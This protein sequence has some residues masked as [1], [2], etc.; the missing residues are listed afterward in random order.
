MP[1]VSFDRIWSQYDEDTNEKILN[2]IKSTA[3]HPL[4]SELEKDL[5]RGPREIDLVRSALED[6]MSRAYTNIRKMKHTHQMPDL[7]SASFAYAIERL[8]TSYG[9]H[10]IFP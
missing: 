9:A 4:D 1:H 10:G 8:A 2:L 3:A 5:H 6:T 7:R